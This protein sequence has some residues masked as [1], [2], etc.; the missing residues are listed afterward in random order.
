MVIGK[1]LPT[2]LVDISLPKAEI[3]NIY[4]EDGEPSLLTQQMM[5]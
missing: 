1:S 5:T 3:L 2:T 4:M